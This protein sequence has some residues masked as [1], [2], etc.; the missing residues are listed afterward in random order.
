MFYRKKV[1]E[2]QRVSN[3]SLELESKKPSSSNSS[4]ENK[5]SSQMSLLAGAIKRKSSE[6]TNQPTKS[7]KKGKIKC[8]S[9]F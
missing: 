6:D 3:S 7:L 2:M 8:K 1:A 4:G 5:R 9:I